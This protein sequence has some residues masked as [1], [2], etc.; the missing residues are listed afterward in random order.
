[1]FPFVAGSCSLLFVGLVF[2]ARCLL[3]ADWCLCVVV[4]CWLSVDCYGLIVAGCSLI[5]GRCVFVVVWRSALLVVCC[6]LRGFVVCCLSFVVLL[7]RVAC[8]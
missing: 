2:V 8:C 4:A 3:F 6:S 1:M 5:V 7:S